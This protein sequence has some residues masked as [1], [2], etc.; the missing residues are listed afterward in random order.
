ML[1]FL[2]FCPSVYRCACMGIVSVDVQKRKRFTAIFRSNF[3]IVNIFADERHTTTKT[4]SIQFPWL[5]AFEP[6][7]SPIHTGSPNRSMHELRFVCF[8][9]IHWLMPSSMGPRQDICF[10]LKYD[11]LFYFS[12]SSFFVVVTVLDSSFLYFQWMA[13]SITETST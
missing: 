13:A 10:P 9:L 3:G 12:F 8:Y 7:S 1:V 11:F 5:T 2:S 4:N 6:F